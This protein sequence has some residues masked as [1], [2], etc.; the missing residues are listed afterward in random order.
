MQFR[1]GCSVARALSHSAKDRFRWRYLVS[2]VQDL[3]LDELQAR[4]DKVLAVQRGMG[5]TGWLLMAF[6]GFSLLYWNGRLFVA[7]GAGVGVMLLVYV[8]QG[9]Q[10]DLNWADLRRW[11]KQLLRGWNQAFLLSVGAGA[12]ATVATYLAVALY[13]ESA[14]P[15]VASAAILQGMG[16]LTVLLILIGQMVQR[17]T[18][19]DRPKFDQV[20]QQLTHRDPLRRVIAV[21][22]VTD[23]V[24]VLDED[25]DYRNPINSTGKQCSRR[26]IADYLRIMLSQESHPIVREAVLD[27]LQTLDLVHQLQAATQPLMAQPLVNLTPRK[28]VPVKPRSV[29]PH[30]TPAMQTPI[31]P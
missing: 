12:I 11:T 31:Q 6:G 16:T 14:S 20:L 22:Q 13:A 18:T 17:Q 27:G 2:V 26:A 28:K 1:A 21:R 29:N 25:I 4:F 15:W 10:P 24:S 19:R 30:S 8:L 3:R 7:T 5:S 9:W 23:W